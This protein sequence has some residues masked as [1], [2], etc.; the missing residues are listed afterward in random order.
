MWERDFLILIFRS[1]NRDER[2]IGFECIVIRR[3]LKGEMILV[4]FFYQ[5]KFKS[6]ILTVFIYKNSC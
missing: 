4:G 5:R 6:H 2:A 3:I 1:L